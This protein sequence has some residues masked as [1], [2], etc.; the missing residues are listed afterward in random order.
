[1]TWRKATRSLDNA[2]CVEVSAPAWR[3]SS[4][5][6][7]GDC[8]EV[9]FYKATASC[10]NAACVEVSTPGF[11]KALKSA[12]TANCV[13]VSTPGFRAAIAS[14]DLNCVEVADCGCGGDVLI[15]DS[16]DPDGPWLSVPPAVFGGFLAAIK[17]GALDLS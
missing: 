8:V 4:S 6:I 2:T 13:E 12:D 17:T 7:T 16:K 3:K 11:R 5:S 1:M 10:G 14:A 9:S 15:R